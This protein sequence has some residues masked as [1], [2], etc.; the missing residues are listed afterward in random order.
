[1]MPLAV[2]MFAESNPAFAAFVAIGFCRSFMDVA[3]A[4]P[5]IA[6]FYLAVPIACSDDLQETFSSTNATTGLLAWLTRYPEVRFG[7]GVRLDAA[8]PTVSAGIQLALLSKALRLEPDGSLR[9]GADVP[10]KGVAERLSPQ[11]KQVLKRAERLGSWMAKAGTA[12]AVYS[13]FGVKP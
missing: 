7:L 12:A 8:L 4:A 3:D 13:A 5:S 1:M 6:L 11:P 9:L 2:D 10:S